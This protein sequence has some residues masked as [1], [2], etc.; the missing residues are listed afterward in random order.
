MFPLFVCQN[1]IISLYN[2]GY[3]KMRRFKK[4]FNMK[5]VVPH[6]LKRKPSNFI[7]GSKEKWDE[8]NSILHTFFVNLV[9]EAETHSTRVVREFTGIGLRDT[10]Y[11]VD[12]P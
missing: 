5:N 8:I 4:Q 10:E 7:I 11:K 6:V 9:P 2:L 3:K 1:A 12:F